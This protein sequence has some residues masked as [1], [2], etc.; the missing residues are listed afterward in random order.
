MLK[1]ASMETMVHSGFTVLSTDGV[2]AT[3]Q[4]LVDLTAVIQV[5]SVALPCSRTCPANFK[6]LEFSGV[7]QDRCEVLPWRV[8]VWP[9]LCNH[10]HLL[11]R[12]YMAL[13]LSQVITVHARIFASVY[14]NSA[15]ASCMVWNETAF[16]QENGL[17]WLH[18]R[19]STSTWGQRT[20][21]RGWRRCPGLRI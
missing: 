4:L 17:R 11:M 16:E 12:C 18:A 13:C 2:N 6:A 3:V 9:A 7:R 20:L 21:R 10:L 14:S 8:C 1:T 15:P 5:R 19:P